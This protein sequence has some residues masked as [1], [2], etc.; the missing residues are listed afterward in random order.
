MGPIANANN[1]RGNLKLDSMQVIIDGRE[2]FNS[3]EQAYRINANNTTT[4]YN[5]ANY[6]NELFDQ[7]TH[8]QL[9]NN[10]A[11]IRNTQEMKNSTQ[12]IT[13]VVQKT[14]IDTFLQEIF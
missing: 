11:N 12:A 13:I 7:E 1:V 5:L 6:K 2:S 4:T 3:Q 9:I 14:K 8:L 10:L